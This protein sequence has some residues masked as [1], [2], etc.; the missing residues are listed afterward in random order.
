MI[1]ES[2]IC[3]DPIK[4]AC[5]VDIGNDDASFGSLPGDYHQKGSDCFGK[6]DRHLK[7][8]WELLKLAN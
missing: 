6:E 7:L 2:G 5:L 8:S 3:S 1:K 4:A